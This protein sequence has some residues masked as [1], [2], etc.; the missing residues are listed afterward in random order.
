MSEEEFCKRFE[1]RVRLHCRSGKR[2]F[3]MVPEEYCARVAKLWWQELHGELWTPETCADEDS[4]Y[5]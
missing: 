1:D 2:P 5:W 3:A 4:Y